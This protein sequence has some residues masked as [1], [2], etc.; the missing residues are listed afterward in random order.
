[1]VSTTSTL[2]S[3][4]P[5][6]ASQHSPGCAAQHDSEGETPAPWDAELLFKGRDTPYPGPGRRLCLSCKGDFLLP[7]M[8]TGASEH[9]CKDWAGVRSG[10]PNEPMPSSALS[11]PSRLLQDVHCLGDQQSPFSALQ[12]PTARALKKHTIIIRD[13][14]IISACDS[15]TG[16]CSEHHCCAGSLAFKGVATQA[17]TRLSNQ[18]LLQFTVITQNF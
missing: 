3:S 1:M 2:E 12:K 7:T 10:A 6:L 18:N 11:S 16:S 8:T 4:F 5:A 17:I 9:G 14:L 15:L 13:E